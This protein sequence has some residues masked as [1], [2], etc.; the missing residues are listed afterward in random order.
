MRAAACQAGNGA[1]NP[2]HTGK[3]ALAIWTTINEARRKTFSRKREIMTTLLVRNSQIATSLP[4]FDTVRQ[5]PP[6]ARTKLRENMRQFVAQGAIDFG[7][8]VN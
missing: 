8:M 6:P 7:R 2:P 4:P 1:F 3:I 5:N